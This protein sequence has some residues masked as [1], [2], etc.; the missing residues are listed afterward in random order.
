MN[1]TRSVKLLGI[2]L[3]NTDRNKLFE[4]NLH[5]HIHS[6][7]LTANNFYIHKHDFY[8]VCTYI[9]ALPLLVVP[10]PNKKKA[11]NAH[12]E[13]FIPLKLVSTAFFLL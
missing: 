1:S 7:T 6:R 13:A 12:I 4:H 2:L 9:D 3:C 8:C 10:K 11:G 5:A